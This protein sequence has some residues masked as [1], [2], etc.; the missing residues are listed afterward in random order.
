MGRGVLDVSHHRALTLL[1]DHHQAP[2]PL[3][4][5]RAAM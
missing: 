1:S 3:E 4:R 2:L 5:V